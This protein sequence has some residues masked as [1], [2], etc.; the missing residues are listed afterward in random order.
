MKKPNRTPE[1]LIAHLKE[2]GVKFNNISEEEA[3]D[4]L[5]NESYYFKLA[6]ARKNYRKDI[7]GNYINLDFSYL[8]ELSKLDRDLRYL[9]FDLCLD[10]EH[11]L[12]RQIVN[13]VCNNTDGY[14]PV[15]EYLK[16]NPSL[17]NRM[18]N[19]DNDTSYSHNLFEKYYPDFPIWVFVEVVSFGT[20]TS[21]CAFYND[22]Y[23]GTFLSNKILNNVRDIRNAVAHNTC[24]LTDFTN[25]YQVTPTTNINK[26]VANCNIGKA[27]RKNNLSNNI[28][29]DIVCLLY[30]HKVLVNNNDKLKEFKK[31]IYERCLIH[32]DYFTN[33]SQILRAYTFIRKIVDTLN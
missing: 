19:L 32:K 1:E 27:S 22:L 3:I 23:S 20:I 30:A 24:I 13:T 2:K 14:E 29:Y 5:T 6:S 16:V 26:F 4:Y 28:I 11:H 9:L 18:N 7:N 8:V 12:K 31:F 21:F 10:I 17:L 33:N 15:H 25:L